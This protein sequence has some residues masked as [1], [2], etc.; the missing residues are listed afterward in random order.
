[1]YGACRALGRQTTFRSLLRSRYV[2]SSKGSTFAELADAL[3][4]RGLHT[5]S[6]SR[7]DISTL[8]HCRFPVILHVR[9]DVEQATA[10]HFVLYLGDVN[11]RAIVMNPPGQPALVSFRRI[12]AVW[13]GKGVIV[14]PHDINSLAI[15]GYAYGKFL[16]MVL[17][18]LSIVG[19]THAA[20]K[21][22]NFEILFNR[23]IGAVVVQAMGIL[24]L[25]LFIGVAQNA[26]GRGGLLAPAGE[27]RQLL[28]IYSA[29]DVP[30]VNFKQAV[31][32]VAQG[33]V[34]IDARLSSDYDAGHIPGAI[35]IPPGTATESRAQ[36]LAG[37]RKGSPIM[38]YCE[39]SGCPL[40]AMLAN[41]LKIDGY[42]R[43]FVFTGGWR[44]WEAGMKA[45][46]HSHA[47]T[48]TG[49]AG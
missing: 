12:A 21:T 43:V 49:A 13:D 16:A 15:F 8:A 11:G 40:A 30:H 24:A 1:V 4:A 33:T 25:A 39:S 44:R 28:R 38:V 47:A 17:V 14:S 23:N 41:R 26:L 20:H 22:G 46:R 45:T 9:S 35:S 32:M 6:V 2:G 5:V 18:L 3:R 36:L 42:G 48:P 29:K 34:V 27:S 19:I 7:M 37:V 10:N 31:A